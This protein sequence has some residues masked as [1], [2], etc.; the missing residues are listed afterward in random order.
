MNKF[1]RDLCVRPQTAVCT[2][3]SRSQA[4]APIGRPYSL[5]S[6]G[7][8]LPLFFLI[9][10]LD[11]QKHNSIS[12]SAP[13]AEVSSADAGATGETP[14]VIAPKIVP[15]VKLGTMRET[16]KEIA[17]DAQTSNAVAWK[18]EQLAG[19]GLLSFKSPQAEDT[20]IA[21]DK[22]GFYWV[23]LTVTSSDGTSAYDD[24]QLL[25]DTTAPQLKVSAEIRAFQPIDIEASIASDATLIRWV[26]IAGPGQVSL[27]AADRAATRVSADVNGTYILRVTAADKLGN[28][29]AADMTFIWETGVPAVSL[30]QDLVTN[31]EISLDAATA[32]ADT[33]QWTQVSGP[34]TLS[35]SPADAEDTKIKATMDGT[36]LVRLTITTAG[37]AVAFDEIQFV[38][39]TAAPVI[40][41]G[42]D[43]NSKYR[44]TLDAQTSGA[45]SFTW[46]KL[47]GPGAVMFSASASE[48]TALIVDQAGI[49]EIGLTA[50]DEAGNQS[51][52][53]V[54][55]DFAYDLRVYAK[56]VSSGGSHSCAILDDASVACWGYNYEQ[57]LGYGSTNKY[58]EGEDRYLPPSFPI[59]LGAGK[60][61]VAIAASYAHS[62]AVLADGSAK[63]W[64]QGSSG[65]LGYGDT[66]RRT[67]PPATG[68]DLGGGQRAR[69]IATGFFHSC[70][71]L[72][73]GGMKCWGL[74]STG[75]LGYGDYK[76]RSAPPATLIDLG[77]GRQAKAISLGG[78][79]TCALLDDDSV[80]CWGSNVNGELGLGDTSSRSKPEALSL[81]LGGGVRTL[82]S[83]GYHTCAVLADAQ[84]KCWGRNK[85]GQLG[86]GD[87]I[88]RLLPETVGIDLGSG[89]KVRDI[90]AGYAHTCAILQDNSAQCWG[91]NSDG[92]LGYGDLI[93]RSAAPQQSVLFGQNRTVKSIAAGRFHNC[94]VLDDDTLKCWGSNAYGQLGSGKFVDGSTPP[95]LAIGY[96]E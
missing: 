53:R 1:V 11:S 22:D 68:I 89:A 36:Y 30:G 29:N 34:G 93:D 24:L 72:E 32:E 75:Q 62:C 40:E 58:G 65:Q 4:F 74:N 56:R 16:N 80:K 10:C 86:Y 42:Q 6:V 57:E 35:F 17:I 54:T 45:V 69:T 73:S 67:A 52:D 94:A 91:S 64:G 20:V 87:T 19:P 15:K 14:T 83:G 2:F 41:L 96:G 84:A 31:Q 76:N 79:H 8:F 26:Q 60:T 44:A 81:A 12:N 13:E 39:D 66:A 9:A 55:I 95:P 88:A 21:A 18:W 46:S 90:A 3:F 48:D 92:Q 33:W 59:N 47:S 82:S 27:S 51:M 71:I 25:W 28:E 61:A 23:R 63:C 49:Y 43:F 78:Y 7:M 77:V 70:A 37:G 85:N 5:L 50:M 38:W